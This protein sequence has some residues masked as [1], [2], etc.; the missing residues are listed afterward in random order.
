MKKVNQNSTNPWTNR[1][2]I[3]LNHNS[4]NPWTNGGVAWTNGVMIKFKSELL[5]PLD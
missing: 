1:A 3:K 5:K 4:S 2:M